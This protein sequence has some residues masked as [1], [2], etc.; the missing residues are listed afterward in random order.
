MAFRCNE[1]SVEVQKFFSEIRFEE[2]ELMSNMM[3]LRQSA[4]KEEQTTKALEG[5][6]LLATCSRGL[7]SLASPLSSFGTGSS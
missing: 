6:G 3:A 7:Q 5:E 2:E 1:A 4:V